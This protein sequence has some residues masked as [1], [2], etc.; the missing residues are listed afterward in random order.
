LGKLQAFQLAN[1]YRQEDG[2][3]EVGRELEGSWKAMLQ[4]KRAPP[5]LQNEVG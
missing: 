3:K 2:R 1:F 4:P 5:M